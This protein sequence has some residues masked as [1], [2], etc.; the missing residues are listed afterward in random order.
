MFH[1][2][3]FVL[4]HAEMTHFRPEYISYM[5]KSLRQM[6]KQSRLKFTGQLPT[7][8]QLT[9]YGRISN[10]NIANNNVYEA[11]IIAKVVTKVYS[12]YFGKGRAVST[13]MK[14]AAWCS[15]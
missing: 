9:L 2:S 4:N 14:V 13:L 7:V 11:V 12:V 10:N 15:G 5:Q 6:M 3:A 8:I 1:F